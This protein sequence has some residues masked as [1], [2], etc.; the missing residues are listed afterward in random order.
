MSENEAQRFCC[1]M[2]D[3]GVHPVRLRMTLKDYARECC[4]L[5]SRRFGRE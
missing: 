4:I 2:L 3:T 1:R 5:K